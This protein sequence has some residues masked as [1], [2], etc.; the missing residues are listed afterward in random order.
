VCEEECAENRI[1][2]LNDVNEA[3]M[4][5]KSALRRNKYIA[6]Y[7]RYSINIYQYIYLPKFLRIFIYL[8]ISKRSNNIQIYVVFDKYLIISRHVKFH[9]FCFLWKTTFEHREVAIEIKTL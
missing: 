8:F 5:I 7:I 1:L 9:L 2:T 4:A 3:V 6:R